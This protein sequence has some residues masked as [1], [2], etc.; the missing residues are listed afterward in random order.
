VKRNLHIAAA[1][2]CLLVAVSGCGQ[3]GALYLPD[4]KPQAV[5]AT[6]ANPAADE[7]ARRK[8]QQAPTPPTTP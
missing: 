5:G 4:A 1:G 2:L 7:A 8:A 3:K 6:P